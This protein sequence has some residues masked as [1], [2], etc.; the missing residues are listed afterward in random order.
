M[1]HN[2]QIMEGMSDSCKYD[3]VRTIRIAL[4]VGYIS[5]NLLVPIFLAKFGINYYLKICQNMANNETSMSVVYA[6]IIVAVLYNTFNFIV[7]L[8]IHMEHKGDFTDVRGKS[9]TLYTEGKAT[10][11]T[12]IILIPFAYTLD[13]LIAVHI[14]KDTG[15]PS[16]IRKIFFCCRCLSGSMQ[17]K[18]IQTLVVW[19]IMIFI[20]GL[21]MSAI[22]VGIF[23]LINPLWLISVCGSIACF[24]LFFIVILSYLLHPCITKQNTQKTPCKR[25]AST[26]IRL[27]G[28]ALSCLFVFHLLTV[29]LT[30]VYRNCEGAFGFLASFLPPL[31]LSITGWCFKS[32]LNF[33]ERS[34]NIANVHAPQGIVQMQ[35]VSDMEPL[36]GIKTIS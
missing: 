17:S 21:A 35:P 6:V 20:Q 27:I 9:T 36:L 5:L 33:Q 8:C 11:I 15:L 19:H 13:L 1:K 32:K 24:T 31:I 30:M 34:Y 26:C 23:L 16:A 18:I 3:T 22:P 4:L 2:F 25:Y 10:F 14:P 28:I 29:Y 7:S 12:R